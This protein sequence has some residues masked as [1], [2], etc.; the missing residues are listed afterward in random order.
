MRADSIIQNMNGTEGPIAEVRKNSSL[1]LDNCVLSGNTNLDPE[2]GAEAIR[3]EDFLASQ[4]CAVQVCCLPY[5]PSTAVSQHRRVTY[6]RLFR[7]N[8]SGTCQ[9]Q[10]LVPGGVSIS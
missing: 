2:P 7:C 3:I 10:P 1:V 9:A 4:P 8:L 5:L 6:A